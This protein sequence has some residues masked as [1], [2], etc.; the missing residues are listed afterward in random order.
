MD[1]MNKVIREF[2]DKFVVVFVDDILIYSPFKEEHERH[3]RTI[4]QL[5][6]EHRLY[7]KFEKYEFWLSEVKFLGHVV[8]GDRVMVDSSKI[9]PVQN[10]EQ[11]KNAPEVRSFLGLASYYRRFVKNLS[12]IA[13]PLTRLTRKGV[14]FV[15]SET[16]KNAFRELKLRLTTAPI[17]IILERGLS[18]T[19]YCDASREGLG[20]VLM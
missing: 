3:L 18:Y 2:L 15:W 7:A 16:C 6:R 14:R 12:S 11:P 4:L 8:S 1:L 20:C 13:S 17:L 19:V 5:L 9:E 10:W